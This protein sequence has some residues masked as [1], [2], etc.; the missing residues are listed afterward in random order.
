MWNSDH[1]INGTGGSSSRPGTCRSVILFLNKVDQLEEKVKKGGL[2][3]LKRY[4]AP[5][6]KYHPSCQAARKELAAGANFDAVKAK[7]FIR[8]SFLEIASQQQQQQ[9]DSTSSSKSAGGGGGSSSSSTGGGGGVSH[10]CYPHFTCA[11]DTQDIGRL[12]NDCCRDILQRVHLR[13]HE[14]L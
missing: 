9:R 5:L 3:V 14:I 7:Y 6:D 13:M 4:F 1:C 10:Q 12:I 2:D 11:I 8:D